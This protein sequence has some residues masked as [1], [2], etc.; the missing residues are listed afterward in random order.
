MV[1]VKISLFWFRINF[2]EVMEEYCE[3]IQIRHFR[4]TS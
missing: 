2:M 1:W 3:P 4:H